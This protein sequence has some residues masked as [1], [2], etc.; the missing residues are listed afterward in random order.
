MLYCVSSEAS[1]LSGHCTALRSSAVIALSTLSKAME[2]NFINFP[3]HEKHVSAY[4]DKYPQ[5]SF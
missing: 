3:T 4:S 1:V 2:S 5:G